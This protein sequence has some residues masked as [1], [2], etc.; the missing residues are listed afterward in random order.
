MACEYFSKLVD[1]FVARL[2]VHRLQ[3]DFHD[4]LAEDHTLAEK[5]KLIFPNGY[6]E[7]SDGKNLNPV[8]WPVLM[9]L[10]D[11]V[12]GGT[13]KQFAK[14]LCDSWGETFNAEGW[15]KEQIVVL[16]RIFNYLTNYLHMF[17]TFADE[18]CLCPDFT[19]EM[20]FD[21]WWADINQRMAKRYYG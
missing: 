5:I 7:Y 6:G 8:V 3:Q 2:P 11:A 12:G 15:I 18:E 9:E 21:L 10:S 13:S 14:A 20:D 1:G 17:A 19:P 16:R 4:W